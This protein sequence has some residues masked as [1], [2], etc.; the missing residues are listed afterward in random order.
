VCR[1]LMGGESNTSDGGIVA[2][3]GKGRSDEARRHRRVRRRLYMK[4]RNILVVTAVGRRM[5]KGQG[6][7]EVKKKIK[8][9]G[10]GSPTIS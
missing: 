10:R 6:G 4:E 2:R 8:V 7:R 5:S 1:V 3:E 9:E